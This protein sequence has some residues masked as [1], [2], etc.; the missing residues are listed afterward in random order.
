KRGITGALAAAR[1]ITDRKKAKEDLMGKNLELERFNNLM[2]GRELR[3]VELKENIRE[4]KEKL[5][6]N[7][8]VYE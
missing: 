4:L 7:A 2:I 3:M 5:N 6:Q 8:G 1:D